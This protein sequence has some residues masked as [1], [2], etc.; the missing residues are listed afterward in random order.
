MTHNLYIHDFWRARELKIEHRDWPILNLS[1]N[2]MK[3]EGEIH[4]ITFIEENP[5]CVLGLMN[6]SR[7]LLGLVR[8]HD[9]VI[10]NCVHGLNRSVLSALIVC[11]WISFDL[12]LYVHGKLMHVKCRESPLHISWKKPICPIFNVEDPIIS[13]IIQLHP[14]VLCSEWTSTFVQGHC[15]G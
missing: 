8:K 7:L 14:N 6:A 15:P 11:Q 4:N 12:N 10:V 2:K 1:G 9:N 3:V 5:R 13:N